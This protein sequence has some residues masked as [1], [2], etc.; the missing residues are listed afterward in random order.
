M[1]LNPQQLCAVEAD[2]PRILV[3]APAGSG[4]TRVFAHRAARLCREGN[5]RRVLCVTF[6]RAAAE[7]MRER[8][9]ALDHGRFLPEISTL[10]AW[11]ARTLRRYAEHIGRT[12]D[13]TVYDEKDREDLLRAVGQDLR[14]VPNPDR[15]RLSTLERIPEV[16]EEFIRRL[17]DGNA[18]TFDQL[19]ELGAGLLAMDGPRSELINSYDHVLLDEA[20]DTN[21]AQWMILNTI[22][23]QIFA[24]GDP[25][26]GI[27]GWRGADVE[28]L[29]AMATDPGTEVINLITNYRS[30]PPVVD[31]ANRIMAAPW[32]PMVADREQG[33]SARVILDVLDEPDTVSGLVGHAL[34]RKGL[35]PSQIAI[36]GRNWRHLEPIREQLEKDGVP[37]VYGGASV[38][39]WDTTDGRM[40]A[41]AILFWLNPRDLNLARWLDGWGVGSPRCGDARE[42]RAEVFRSRSSVLEVMASVS[43]FW[44]KL[45]FHRDQSRVHSAPVR[46]LGSFLAHGFTGADALDRVPALEALPE[47][48]TDAQSFRGWWLT[49]GV[50]ERQSEQDQEGVT[51]TT[52]HGAK[53]LEWDLVVMLH[54]IEGVYPTSRKTATDGEREEDRRVFYVGCTRA[55]EDLVCLVPRSR[56][57]WGRRVVNADPSPLLWGVGP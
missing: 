32:G 46:E 50:Q 10:H 42:V 9:L 35:D 53:G 7:E 33:G 1:I 4:K 31:A 30:R 8:I 25:R 45:A 19:E 41:R 55:R 2:H 57:T 12:P 51:V 44:F 20:Q 56:E 43:N 26:Q 5:P 28:Q 47:S 13:F 54:C 37:L 22:G 39:P 52:V 17:V 11:C 29:Q 14:A 36:L 18:L 40:L 16:C 38:D 48:V 15:C 27:Y 21:A 34:A 24:V 3:V 49:R 6:T 23:R